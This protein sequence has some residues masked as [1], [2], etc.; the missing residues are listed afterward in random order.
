MYW[1]APFCESSAWTQAPLPGF[2]VVFPRQF[3]RMWLHPHPSKQR[4]FEPQ[5][6][7]KTTW[8]YTFCVKLNLTG[9]KASIS[10]SAFFLASTASSY[11][12]FSISSWPAMASFAATARSYKSRG[13]NEQVMIKLWSKC[14]SELVIM[15][16]WSSLTRWTF[17][18]SA[19]LLS[20]L[21]WSS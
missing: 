5:P 12:T 9:L 6:L 14:V 15:A 4:E 11:F 20:S 3:G 21:S 13:R 16:L 19:I 2:P 1:N 10:S 8:C 7:C 17:I 18:W